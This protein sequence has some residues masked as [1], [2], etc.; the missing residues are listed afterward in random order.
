MR[1]NLEK[2]AAKL[3][4]GIS[5]DQEHLERLRHG[6]DRSNQLLEAAQVEAD[7][8]R[9]IFEQLRVAPAK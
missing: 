2:I 9:T 4:V 8:S 1:K 5:R 7:E 6:W 3:R